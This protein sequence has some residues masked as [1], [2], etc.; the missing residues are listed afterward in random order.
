MVQVRWH[1]TSPAHRSAAASAGLT[2]AQLVVGQRLGELLESSEDEGALDLAHGI[3]QDGLRG[4]L[5]CQLETVGDLHRPA[6]RLRTDTRLIRGLRQHTSDEITER[7]CKDGSRVFRIKYDLC[8]WEVDRQINCF[9]Y[10]AKIG[11]RGPFLH[12]TLTYLKR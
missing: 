3:L 9:H 10:G 12:L 7:R 1:F 2:E 4:E 11:P 5:T 6:Y 8:C